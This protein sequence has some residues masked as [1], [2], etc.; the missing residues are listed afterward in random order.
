MANKQENVFNRKKRREPG[1]FS[2]LHRLNTYSKERG[3]QSVK[4]ENDGVL[5]VRGIAASKLKHI[6]KERS[7]N[8]PY[9]Q[10]GTTN[11]R[12]IKSA[13]NIPQRSM[14]SLFSRS[15]T[16]P[17]RRPHT[18]L[19]QRTNKQCPRG[20]DL[21]EHVR[22]CGSV[23][24]I[25]IGVNGCSSSSDV[26]L[27]R[28]YEENEVLNTPRKAEKSSP[29]IKIM[30]KE[31]EEDNDDNLSTVRDS[32]LLWSQNHESDINKVSLPDVSTI[33]FVPLCWEDQFEKTEVYNSKCTEISIFLDWED[34][35]L[36]VHNNF[37][38][39]VTV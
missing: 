32:S 29:Q 11:K 10:Q 27:D 9:P 4:N 17:P 33:D 20:F 37:S 35:N 34:I 12:L 13:S 26:Y 1:N 31:E 2:K 5:I 36:I 19:G 30:K 24:G 7:Q 18:S 25:R 21:E 6:I 3:K 22:R 15:S 14:S 16:H 28:Y 8:S 39:F 23:S 38:I